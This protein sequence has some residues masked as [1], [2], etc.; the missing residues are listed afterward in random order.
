MEGLQMSD[1]LAYLL[2]SYFPGFEVWTSRINDKTYLTVDGFVAYVLK[3]VGG[4]IAIEDMTLLDE[5]V[6]MYR[7]EELGKRHDSLYAMHAIVNIIISA[8]KL[9]NARLITSEN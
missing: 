2:Q 4:L 1:T 9:Y 8:R 5:Y 6:S 7:D 3:E